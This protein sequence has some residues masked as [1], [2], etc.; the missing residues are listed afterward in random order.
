MNLK[1]IG[2]EMTNTR[3]TSHIR[4][5]DKVERGQRAEILLKDPLLKQTLEGLEDEYVK[6]WKQARTL[7]AREDAHRLIHLIERFRDHLASLSVAISE[8]RTSE[9][10]RLSNM[11]DRHRAL[12]DHMENNV[13]PELNS[14]LLT[15]S[16]AKGWI[17]GVGATAGLA[18]A[19]ITEIIRSMI[20][21]AS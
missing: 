12:N 10:T 8:H 15:R 19:T 13:A 2:Q 3:D 1:Q 20:K 21:G 16:R 11:E 17:A 14:L 7:D 9:L 18:A 4:E 5:F 6:A